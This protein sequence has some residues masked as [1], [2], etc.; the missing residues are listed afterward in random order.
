MWKSDFNPI[1][2]PQDLRLL[3]AAADENRHVKGLDDGAQNSG[4][5]IAA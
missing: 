4:R 3:G 1:S 2:L 5:Q